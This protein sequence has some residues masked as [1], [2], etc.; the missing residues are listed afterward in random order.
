MYVWM[1]EAWHIVAINKWELIPPKME[2]DEMNGAM[3]LK[4]VFFLFLVI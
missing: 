2:M 4:K 1:H 3:N